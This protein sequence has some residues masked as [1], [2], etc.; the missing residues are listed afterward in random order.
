MNTIFNKLLVPISVL[1]L[2][3][4]FL[5]IPAAFAQ[6]TTL[7]EIDQLH[8]ISESELEYKSIAAK[9]EKVLAVNPERISVG[10]DS[11]GGNL[12]AALCLKLNQEEKYL[13][14]YL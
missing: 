7:D 14:K 9:I 4:L 11:A 13:P 2:W 12:A 6:S 3:G 5:N 1:F 8:K 10:G